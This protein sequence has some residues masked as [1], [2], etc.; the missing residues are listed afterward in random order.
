VGNLLIIIQGEHCI[1][2]DALIG[3]KTVVKVVV[4]CAYHLHGRVE[5]YHHREERLG[6]G[7]RREEKW[8]K[9]RETGENWKDK[10]SVILCLEQRVS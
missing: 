5:R 10:E 1:R 3:K 2:L 4:A 7:K 8:G 9:K 6:E